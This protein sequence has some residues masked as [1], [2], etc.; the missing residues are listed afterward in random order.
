MEYLK[1]KSE[2][3]FI[4]M[5]I[6]PTS[7]YTLFLNYYNTGTQ[8]NPL[9]FHH[10]LKDGRSVQRMLA[11]LILG[12]DITIIQL[13]CWMTTKIEKFSYLFQYLNIDTV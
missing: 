10:L 5:Y 13:T 12:R 3:G 6:Q 8:M 4:V 2:D 1:I 11:K 7:I 9:T